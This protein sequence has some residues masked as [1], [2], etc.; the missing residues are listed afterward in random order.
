MISMSGAT[1][2]TRSD[3]SE[4]M[5]TTR[6]LSNSRYVNGSMIASGT[7]WRRVAERTVSAWIRTAS[8]RSAGAGGHPVGVED[9]VDVAQ[10]ADRRLQ[11][12]GVGDLY[13]E[14]VLDHR[15]RDD[16]ARLDDVD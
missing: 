14:A 9:P 6:R 10:L 12:L 5:T 8:M 15:A 3:S 4:E 7:S 16:A 1:P 11:R 13:N 2:A